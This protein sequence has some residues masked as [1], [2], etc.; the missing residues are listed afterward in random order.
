M[1]IIKEKPENN[2]FRGEASLVPYLLLN[3]V[4]KKILIVKFQ[5]T[6]LK[7]LS[8]VCTAYM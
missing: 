7:L 6:Y 1:P 4:R 2:Y 3:R 5:V 8:V